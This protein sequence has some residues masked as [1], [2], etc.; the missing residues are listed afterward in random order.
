MKQV[1]EFEA[2]TK[3]T[4]RSRSRTRGICD[5]IMNCIEMAGRDRWPSCPIC[6]KCGWSVS[7]VASA[8]PSS[9][10]GRR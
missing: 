3:E 4:V 2:Q 8:S 1:M 5:K 7:V 9:S 6:R 10:G